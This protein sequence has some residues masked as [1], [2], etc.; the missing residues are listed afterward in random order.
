MKVLGPFQCQ[1]VRSDRTSV[2]YVEIRFARLS[3]VL[4]FDPNPHRPAK[5]ASGQR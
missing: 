1:P 5:A 4:G 2:G 3:S